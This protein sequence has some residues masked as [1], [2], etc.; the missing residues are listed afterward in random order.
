MM[1]SDR[2]HYERRVDRFRVLVN[3]APIGCV[4]IPPGTRRWEAIPQGGEPLTRRDGG[5]RVTRT[6][7]SRDEAGEALNE[8][9][10]R[11]RKA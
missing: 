9:C 4:L 10:G 7:G 11:R 6:F 5:M 1:K 2:I 3:G 8:E